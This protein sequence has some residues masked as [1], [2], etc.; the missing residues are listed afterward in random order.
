MVSVVASVVLAR[1]EERGV[2][3]PQWLK[4]RMPPGT[5]SKRHLIVSW[6]KM[7]DGA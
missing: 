3:R 2:N 5:C 6:E 7:E 4:Y 1:A